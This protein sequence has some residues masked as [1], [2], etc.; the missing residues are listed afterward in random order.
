[1]KKLFPTT[2][3]LVILP[4]LLFAGGW[5]EKRGGG[6]FR[7]DQSIFRST[8]YIDATGTSLP[9][10]TLSTYTTSFY[11]QYGI[12]DKRL[13]AVTYLPLFVRN[14]FNE[15]V[16]RQSDMVLE[17]GAANN[18]FGDMDLG[19]QVGILQDKR[20]VLSASVIF[21][22]PTGD[23][24]DENGLLTG[25]GEFNQLF[26]VDVGQSFKHQP[27]YL[28]GMLGVN[29]RTKGFSDEFRYEVEA[30]YTWSKKLLFSL[31]IGGI[32]PFRNGDTDANSGSV[33]LFASNVRFTYFTPE[34]AYIHKEQYGVAFKMI[35]ATRIQNAL[36]AP[37][38]QVGVFYKLKPKEKE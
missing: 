37:T 14:T 16:G 21:G 22:I 38:F 7:L 10:R 13:M 6:Y 18:S 17:P 30:G 15:R 8:T 35:T 33:G 28:N 2:L 34:I 26:K 31:K 19:F 12:I 36:G 1:M 32:E 25:D 23:S 29:Q 5:N 4:A 9:I 24:D 11:G 3:L 20:T 27:I